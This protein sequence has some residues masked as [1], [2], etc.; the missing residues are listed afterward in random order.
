MHF[1]WCTPHLNCFNESLFSIIWENNNTKQQSCRLESKNNLKWYH[2][3]GTKVL[4]Q[5]VWVRWKETMDNTHDSI[6]TQSKST[7]SFSL[8]PDKSKNL[9]Q[10]RS[11][12]STLAMWCNY[13]LINI[14]ISTLHMCNNPH[15]TPRPLYPLQKCLWLQSWFTIYLLLA[16]IKADMTMLYS[17]NI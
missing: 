12:G 3:L 9:L 17:Q 5:A 8:L 4:Y 14:S 1:N 2:Y 15:I 11:K 10:D 6:L 16:L 7:I 13:I